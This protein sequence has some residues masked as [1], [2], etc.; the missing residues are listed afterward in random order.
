MIANKL[1]IIVITIVTA[2]FF[3]IQSVL[4][5]LSFEFHVTSSTIFLETMHSTQKKKKREFT[6][7]V[8]MNGQ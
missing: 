4:N 3:F 5:Q 1:F 2:F 8:E 6:P 7:Y